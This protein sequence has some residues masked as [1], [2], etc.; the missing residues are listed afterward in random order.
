MKN[1]IASLV[2]IALHRNAGALL[3]PSSNAVL[4]SSLS[5]ITGHAR[6]THYSSYSS[7]SSSAASNIILRAV[8]R[9]KRY[10][11]TIFNRRGKEDSEL[12]SSNRDGSWGN[13]RSSG[14]RRMMR[15]EDRRGYRGGRR[16]DDRRYNDDRQRSLGGRRGDDR[17]FGGR[18]NGNGRMYDDYDYLEQRDYNNNN[19]GRSIF[20]SGDYYPRQGSSENFR[21]SSSNPR[22]QRDN[23]G[24]GRGRIQDYYTP[25]ERE[26]QQQRMNDGARYG[27]QQQYDVGR[28][29]VR[30][31]SS[32]ENFRRGKEYDRVQDFLTP[33]ERE[34]R[35]QRQNQGARYG[36]QQQ[37]NTGRGNVRQGSSNDFRRGREYDDKRDFMTP[38]ERERLQR[39]DNRALGRGWEGSG[40]VYDNEGDYSFVSGARRDYVRRDGDQDYFGNDYMTPRERERMARLDNRAMG[41]GWEGSD[42]IY[43]NEGDYSFVSGARRDFV[44]RDEYQDYMGGDR[45]GYNGRGRDDYYEPE[46]V[47]R[48]SDGGSFGLSPY[49]RRG[50]RRGGKGNA[51]DSLRDVF[52]L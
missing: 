3:A 8:P 6:H 51:W 5:S 40:N 46:I 26:R 7:Y 33:R 27:W 34:E 39:L 29:N 30:R 47:G 14:G 16:E 36:W 49:G 23:G 12:R 11:R 25:G 28:G 41:R 48:R 32:S 35:Q 4:P 42:Y 10:S 15:E 9:D 52:K 1:A 31:G 17:S 44:R 24:R 21:R 2:W 45:Y 43:D 50:E 20:G 19:N 18:A 13:N 38:R 37:Y 22:Y